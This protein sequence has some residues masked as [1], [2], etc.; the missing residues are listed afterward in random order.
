MKLEKIISVIFMSVVISG[1]ACF[2]GLLFNII[3]PNSISLIPKKEIKKVEAVKPSVTEIEKQPKT[4]PVKPVVSKKPAVIEVIAVE[5]KLID[6]AKTKKYFDAGKAVFVDARPEFVYVER[7]IKGAV[8]LSASRFNYQYERIKDKLNKDGLYIIYCSDTNCH[9]SD[10]VAEHLKERG[11]KNI[12]IFSAGWNEW[13][14]SGYPVEGVKVKT[15]ITPVEPPEPKVSTPAQQI[16]SPAV[17]PKEIKKPVTSEVKIPVIVEKKP[18]TQEAPM[19]RD[20]TINL[21][22][23]KKYFDSGKVVFVDARPEY[24]YV[25]R[26]IKGA[27]SLSASR[28]NLQYENMK[29]KLKKDD[30]YIVYCS[31]L[32]CHLS[33]YVAGYLEERGF[34][35]VKVFAAGWDEWYGAGY[36]I[37]GLKVKKGE[38]S[39]E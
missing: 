8:S 3:N 5:E 7:H 25:E 36:P 24:V 19:P 16:K 17:E 10:L 29:D 31:S 22:Q 18:V 6:L 30:L 27:V 38:A 23:T 34:K 9:L 4:V 39:G 28:F 37:E 21:E 33:G 20:N 1:F 14:N 12:K 26:H 2:F 32:T 11:F 15:A 35:N 13:N